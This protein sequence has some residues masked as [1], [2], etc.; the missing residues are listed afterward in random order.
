MVGDKLVYQ[1]LLGWRQPN[2][3]Y[4]MRLFESNLAVS[5]ICSR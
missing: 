5:T 1:L 4:K 2:E 3:N